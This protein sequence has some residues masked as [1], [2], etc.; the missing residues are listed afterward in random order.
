MPRRIV[1]LVLLLTS[2][3]TSGVVTGLQPTSTTVSHT[4]DTDCSFPLTTTD[5]TGEQ[6]TLQS[7]PTQIVALAPSDAQILWDINASDHVVGMPVSQYTAYLN[8][9]TTPTDITGQDG[10]TVIIERV[11]DLEPDLV[12]A[13]NITNPET[14]N[15]LRDANITVYHFP[16]ATN[17]ENII[18]NTRTSGILTGECAG[19]QARI[20]WMKQEITAIQQATTDQPKPLV[21]LA[22]GDGWTAGSDTFQHEILVLAGAEN[23]A[24]RANITGWQV[25]S[26]EIVHT[27]DPDWIVY[28][29][30]FED[31]P[32]RQ[33]D[34]LT[35]AYETNQTIAVNAQYL[36]QPGPRVVIVIKELARQFHP[37]FYNQT[38]TPHNTTPP[39][40]TTPTPTPTQPGL[41]LLTTGLALGLVVSY[42][43]LREQ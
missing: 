13:G 9:H 23:I 31:P 12:L 29:D 25:I 7:K 5:A 42:L 22:M 17:L 36:N 8:D 43:L 3:L 32:L 39:A 10:L 16:T 40:T 30:T 28:S 37:Q 18:Q 21:L 11:V 19:A 1:L 33:G 6:I 14:I 2:V 34:R 38:Q 41:T 15:R 24:S 27:E 20:D 35:T 26:E 4:P